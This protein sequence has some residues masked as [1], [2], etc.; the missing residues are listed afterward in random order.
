[1]KSGNSNIIS[2]LFKK[3]LN[4]IKKKLD[5]LRKLLVTSLLKYHSIQIMSLLIGTQNHVFYTHMCIESR[6]SYLQIRRKWPSVD[7]KGVDLRRNLKFYFFYYQRSTFQRSRFYRYIIRNY[8]CRHSIKRTSYLPRFHTPQLSI[9]TYWFSF[10]ILI[11]P[12]FLWRQVRGTN[13]SGTSVG[14]SKYDY[15]PDHIMTLLGIT[16]PFM[17]LI[18]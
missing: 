9:N 4:P 14:L 10:L 11:F 2:I 8:K 13:P 15:L 18:W 7:H 12:L 1:M 6:K 17:W 16:S 5:L 3:V